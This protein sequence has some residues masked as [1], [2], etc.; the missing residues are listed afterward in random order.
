MVGLEALRYRADTEAVDKWVVVLGP[1]QNYC[2]G[3]SIRER[4]WW[5]RGAFVYRRFIYI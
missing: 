5:N 3:C 4:P 1:R 2:S